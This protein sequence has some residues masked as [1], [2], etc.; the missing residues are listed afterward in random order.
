M[1][2]KAKFGTVMSGTFNAPNLIHAFA[3]ELRS[4]RGA[5]PFDIYTAVKT[6]DNAAGTDRVHGDDYQYLFGDLVDALNE[7]APLYGY[8]GTHLGD[9]A[10]YGFWLH[11]EWEDMFDGLKVADTGEVPKG[12]IGEVMQVSDHGN[13]TLYAS[14]KRGKLKEIWSLV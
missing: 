12:Y 8:F 1:K 13:L 5:L 2:H 11:D 3:D 7:Y 10:D 9:G 6:F 4:L 14:N